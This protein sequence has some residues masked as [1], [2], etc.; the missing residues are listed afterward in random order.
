LSV[1]NLICYLADKEVTVSVDVGDSDEIVRTDEE[2]ITA[3]TDTQATCP[4]VPTWSDIIAND[5]DAERDH[6]KQGK[7]REKPQQT[8][9][10][11]KRDE[12]SDDNNT[13]A[14]ITPLPQTTSP[15]HI[16][17]FK[18]DT[19]VLTPR[20]RTRSQSRLKMPSQP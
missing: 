6:E 20:E 12:E 4:T 15:K 19:D 2:L 10:D 17:K 3:P 5:A 14:G 8:K 13:N 18:I 16:K 1:G 7:K 11:N 9:E